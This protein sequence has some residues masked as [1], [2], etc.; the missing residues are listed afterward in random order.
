[1]SKQ[2]ILILFGGQSAEHEI[3]LCSAWNVISN[4]DRSK[5]DLILVGID[6]Q[7]Q[8]FL[9]SESEFLKQEPFAGT[10]KLTNQ[11]NQI[12][13]VPGS[14]K[15]QL[16]DFGAKEMLHVDVAFPMLHGPFG[17]DGTIQGLL[18]H[19]NIPYVGS[20]VLGASVSMDKDVA[21]RLMQQANIP[22]SAFLS[23]NKSELNTIQYG[24][25]VGKLGTPIFIKPANMGSSVGISKVENE[26]GFDQAVTLAFK[27]DNKIIIE[28]FVDGIEVECAVL[29]NTSLQVSFPGRYTHSD[30]FFAYDTKYLKGNEV[31]MEIPVEGL[32]E[33]LIQS[34]RDVSI[35]AYQILE[36]KGLARVDTF[37]TKEG[38]FLVNEVNSIPGFTN[39]SMY[40]LLM[41]H[42][43][44]SYTDLLDRLIELA[45]E[46]N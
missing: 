12:A 13:V 17:E 1:M 43:G 32:S 42:L 7:G 6:K 31:G 37:V 14:K 30:S 35:K 38:D 16:F 28:A 45:K 19:L 39:S 8:W 46:S 25:V 41:K 21:K 40:P 26:N 23:F 2:K 36:C 33:E 3:S 20:K 5:Y 4:M 24:D 18:E 22:T 10:I 9:Q 44:I 34:I 11:K 15:D 27:H 29:G